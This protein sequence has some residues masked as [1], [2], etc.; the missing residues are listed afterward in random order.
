MT[1]NTNPLLFTLPMHEPERLAGPN[2]SICSLEEGCLLKGKAGWVDVQYCVKDTARL[3]FGSVEL[4]SVDLLDVLGRK[5]PAKGVTLVD[6][7]PQFS[8][9]IGDVGLDFQ[10]QNCGFFTKGLRLDEC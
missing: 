9:R 6:M 5:Q 4:L 2:R 8:D 1:L 3:C 10:G 7:V